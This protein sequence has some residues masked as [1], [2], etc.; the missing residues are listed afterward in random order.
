[1]DRRI[2]VI[3]G[4]LIPY[5]VGYVADKNSLSWSATK[6]M[7]TTFIK[8]V[9]AESF[10]T[11]YIIFLG[12]SKNF[13]NEVATI[14]KY[15]AGRATEKCSFYHD[16]K[17][18]IKEE[19]NTFYVNGAE[20]DDAVAVY[21]TMYGEESIIC[22]D[23]KDLLQIPG[24]HFNIRTRELIVVT[25]V[26]A[27][28]RIHHQLLTG[29]STDNIKG[30]EGVGP[31][32]AKKILDNVEPKDYQLECLKQYVLKYG[33]KGVDNCQETFRL[34]YMMREFKNIDLPKPKTTKWN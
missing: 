23:D 25:E 22:S 9:C 3:D 1:M 26:E 13:R 11:E 2:A 17:K 10:A 27:H 32:T 12:G 20:A 31:A 16:I 8:K 33:D 6:D 24:N 30:I 5:R 28:Y 15:K 7:V 4:D 34:I 21:Q 14:A 29:D 19:F 18:Q